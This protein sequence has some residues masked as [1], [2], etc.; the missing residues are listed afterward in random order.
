MAS[1]S[2][3]LMAI[4]AV[5]S[6]ALFNAAPVQAQGLAIAGQ[7]G[8]AGVGGGV[9]VGVAPKIN[10][11]AMYGVVSGDP[12]VDVDDVSFVLDLPSF[13]LTTVDF[14]AIGGLHLSAGGLLITNDGTLN[15]VG[16]FDGIEVDFNGTP[17]TGGSNDRLLGTFV[18]KRFQP[19]LGIG[20]GNPV[21][22]GIGINFDAGVG[23]GTTPT[24]ELN[25]EGPLAEAPAPAGPAFLANLEA[26]EADFEAKIPDLL[27]YYHVLSISISIGL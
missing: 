26:N 9:V 25:A 5:V 12:S 4:V 15:V 21:G 16:T 3:D 7:V 1:H 22:K 11:R 14:Y 23:F 17:Y 10:L 18:L 2:R 13:L 19:Y 8:T 24:V 20:L 27:R 6:A